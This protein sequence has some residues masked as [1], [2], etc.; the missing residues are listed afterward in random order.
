MLSGSAPH[1]HVSVFQLLGSSSGE[2][3]AALTARETFREGLNEGST[4]SQSNEDEFSLCAVT[5][6]MWKT[7]VLE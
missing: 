5:K 4:R 3:G 6:K 2:A 1:H 7:H